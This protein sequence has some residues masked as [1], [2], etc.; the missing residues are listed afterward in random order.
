M[1]LHTVLHEMCIVV[2]KDVYSVALGVVLDAST[3][4]LSGG[5]ALCLGESEDSVRKGL[6]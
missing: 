5:V 1:S 2:G 4:S 3:N 6:S